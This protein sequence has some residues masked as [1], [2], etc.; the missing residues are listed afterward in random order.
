VGGLEAGGTKFVCAVGSG[1]ADV[2]AETTIPTTDPATTLTRV[3][4]FFRAHGPIAALGVGAFGPL[5]LDR[6]SPTF[7][8]ITNTPKRG[9]ANTNVAGAFA[10]LGVPVAID[11]DVNAAA[12]G[13]HRWGAARGIASFVYLTI[14]TG[15]GGGAFVNGALVHGLVHPEMGHIPIPRAAGD[16]FPGI[17]PFHRDCF[18]GLASGPA[19]AARW[20]APAESLPA[21]HPAWDLEADYLALGLAAIVAVLSPERIIVGGGVARAEHLLPRVRTKL[22]A[23]LGGYVRSAALDDA[24]RPYVTAPEL[25]ERAGVL[26]ALALALTAS[27]ATGGG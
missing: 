9:W 16:T 15:I 1:A 24:V 21:H 26:G 12:L 6:K 4:D 14:G 25:G 27:R 18:E 2:R 19:M 22:N 8:F 5:D 3:M 7:G 17:C 20:N 13:E 11:T 10:S 23:T